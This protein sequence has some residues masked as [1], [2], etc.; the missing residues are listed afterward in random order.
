MW[1][2]LLQKFVKF[3]DPRLEP[4]REKKVMP[5]FTPKTTEEFIGVVQRTPKS[6]LD[7]K[8]RDRL[9]AIMSFDD[10]IVANLMVGKSDMVFVKSS[11]MLGPLVLDELY[12]SGYTS[13]PVVNSRGKV[14]GIINTTALNALAVRDLEKAEKYADP[15]TSR[16]H[17]T[18][19]LEFA[20]SEII[21]TGSN[22]FLV[23]DDSEELVGF[24]TTEML[25]HY[26]S[27]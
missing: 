11:E 24:F 15:V 2:E 19:S 7:S 25:F 26:L 12:R 8:A 14:T 3:L 13:F 6:V 22:Y 4:Y 27:L 16:L 18:D 20:V 1:R 23:Y 17:A 21:R 9:A 5:K 10:R